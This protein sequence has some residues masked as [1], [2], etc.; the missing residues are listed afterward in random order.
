VPISWQETKEIL[1]QKGLNFNTPREIE[2]YLKKRQKRRNNKS[3]DKGNL[4]EKHRGI[5]ISCTQNPPK[6]LEKEKHNVLEDTAIMIKKLLEKEIEKINGKN[7]QQVKLEL[8]QLEVR[9]YRITGG[10]ELTVYSKGTGIIRKMLKSFP[11]YKELMYMNEVVV[12]YKTEVDKKLKLTPKDLKKIW[13]ISD[14][15]ETTYDNKKCYSVSLESLPH[16]VKNK[17]KPPRKILEKQKIIAEKKAELLVDGEKVKVKGM[18]SIMKCEVLLF[19]D[20][21]YKIRWILKRPE[22]KAIKNV[23]KRIKSVVKEKIARKESLEINIEEIM[24]ESGKG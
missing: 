1:Q 3:D 16:T 18:P 24:D 22:V 14:K 10:W 21:K 5:I 20:N 2:E 4:N 13:S 17:F 15:R 19:P 9:P 11:G 23:W 8:R 6:S 7:E 12:E